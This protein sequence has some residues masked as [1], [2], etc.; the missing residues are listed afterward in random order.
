M[1]FIDLLLGAIV[2]FGIWTGWRRGLLA[3]GADLLALV[4]S[5]VFALWAWRPLLALAGAH[6]QPAGP[7]A[8]PL[9]F[10]AALLASRIVLGLLLGRLLGAVPPVAHGHAANRTLGTVPGA[11]NGL[12]NATLAAMF[13]VAV[14][15]D[16]ALTQST[17]QSVLAGRLAGPADWL[18]ARLGAIFDPAI[19]EAVARL[20]VRT[21]PRD[22]IDLPYKVA[23]P[24]PRP[25]LEAAM[26]VLVNEARREQGLRPLQADPEIVPVARA[27]SRDMFARGY[28]SHITPEGADPFDRLRRSG[29]RFRTAGENLAVAR[30]LSMAHQGLLDSPGHRANIM[31]PAFGRVGIGILDGGRYGLMVTQKFRN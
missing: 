9:A 13:L 16:D 17:R 1:N 19:D 15:L 28:F 8:A 22:R 5:T 27:H 25:D 26:L 7:W 29:V 30:S 23:Q 12:I 6:A 4:A 14:P 20:T 24:K 11:G 10:A 3:A 21:G 31:Q 2:A 18:Q